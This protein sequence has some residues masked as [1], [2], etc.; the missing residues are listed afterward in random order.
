MVSGGSGSSCQKLVF[1]TGLTRFTG[2]LYC[3]R[4][5]KKRCIRAVKNTPAVATHEAAP[6]KGFEPVARVSTPIQIAH[7]PADHK[8]PNFLT[9][10]RPP[11]EGR[12]SAGTPRVIC[13]FR[14]GRL[15]AKLPV[16]RSLRLE[17]QP[18]LHRTDTKS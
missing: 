9:I 15:R 4:W 18:V 8:I 7:L 2:F 6:C 3:D 1:W 14:R 11:A 16:R 12:C 5:D 17:N 13:Y 10:P